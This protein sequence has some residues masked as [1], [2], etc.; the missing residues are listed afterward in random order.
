MLVRLKAGTGANWNAIAAET[1]AAEV[2]RGG[3]GIFLLHS[4]SQNISKLLERLARHA[5]IE[6]AEPNYILQAVRTP[7]DTN[8]GQLWGLRNNAQTVLGVTGK[9]GVDIAAA[10]AWDISTGNTSQ[11]AAVVDTGVDYN[12]VDLAANMWSAPAAYTVNINGTPVTC[13]AGS[14]GFNLVSFSCDPMDDNDHGTHVAGTIGAAGNNAVGV[15][16]V[17][18]Q[19][20]IMA[21]K[22]LDA[23]G[24]GTSFDAINSLEYLI[25]TKAAFG[26]DGGSADI[27][28]LNASWGGGGFDQ[29][30]LDAIHDANAAGILFVAAAGNDTSNNDLV[31]FY[32]ASFNAPNVIAVAAFNN[33]DQLSWFS[34]FGA[35]SVDLGA[36]GESILSTKRGGGYVYFSGT[37][38]AAPHVTGSA[39]LVLS[40]CPLDTAGLRSVLLTGTSADTALKGK[41]V[42]GGRL[43]VN[44]ALTS[45]AAYVS[46][47]SLSFASTVVGTSS[48]ASVVTIFN[49]QSIPLNISDVAITGDYAVTNSCPATLAAKTKCTMSIVFT[50]ALTG[51]RKGALTVSADAPGAPFAVSISGAGVVPVTVSTT[52]LSFGNQVV[53]STSAAKTVTLTNNQTVPL[54]VGSITTS[55]DF[56]QT[57]TCGLA[58]AAKSSCAISVSFTPTLLGARTGQLVIQDDGAGS[59]RTVALTGTGINALTYAPTSLGFSSYAVGFTTAAKAVTLTNN[60]TTAIGIS[61]IAVTGDFSQTNTCGTSLAGKAVCTISVT[62]SPSVLGSRTGTLT[63]TPAAPNSPITVPLSGSGLAPVTTSSS[64]LGFANQVVGT[65]SLARTVSM[66]NNQP[67]PLNILSIAITGD[68][69]QTN[70]CP[71]ALAPKA[72]CVFQV[73]FT[74]TILGSRPGAL[75]ITHDAG[76]GVANIPLS[77]SGVKA[78]VV[79][80]TSQTY[81]TLPVGTTSAP[82]TVTLTN[83]QTVGL[84]LFSISV[85]GDYAQTNNCPAVLAAKTSCTINITFTPTAV[86]TRTGA[87]TVVDDGPSTPETVPL[88]GKGS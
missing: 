88:S 30:L 5:E 85:S 39:M 19:A 61:G 20:R 59:P 80:P 48:A 51:T 56:T 79:S 87:L 44:K 25:Q 67:V 45:C 55:G 41:T 49:N 24:S 33:L 60:L 9:S 50:P 78:V 76:A 47:V 26:G 40:R 73:V 27:R 70:N 63:I 86:G 7:N 54:N 65:S 38:M 72:N 53:G 2:K 64:S 22:F 6:L 23:S 71:A 11:V 29:F 62:F 13:P 83:N 58:V 10:P 28:A 81:S 43:N 77:G 57:N 12:H 3:R 42:T 66:T 37:S 82:K 69:S 16:G 32:P 68:Y 4:R 14:H 1:D 52:S 74:P 18:W 46:P 21:V 34:N 17:N 75:T 35:A 15:T 84:T 31:P 36:P 8:Y